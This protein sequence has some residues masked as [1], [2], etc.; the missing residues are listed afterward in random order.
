M[1][2]D[3]PKSI[4]LKN[5]F[6]LYKSLKP[7]YMKDTAVQLYNYIS[8]IDQ[9]LHKN[10]EIEIKLGKIKLEGNYKLYEYVKEVFL[11]PN[12]PN[13][14]QDK[15]TFESN[16]PQYFNLIWYYLNKEIE[17]GAKDIILLEPKLYKELIFQDKRLSFC[18]ID[19]KIVSEEVIYKK[20]KH[21][22]NI[23]Y[24][25][26][27]DYRITACLEMPVEVNTDDIL[28]SYREKLRISYKFQ[29]FRV[30]F[31]V[32]KS[33]YNFSKRNINLTQPYSESIKDLSADEL[34][35]PSITYELEVEFDELSSFLKQTN[36]EYQQFENMIGRLIENINIFIN[37]AN[38]NTYLNLTANES[39]D[40]Q[41]GNYFKYNLK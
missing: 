1:K 6:K 3:I 2:D 28:K 32:V 38:F 40:S 18:F 35:Y 20:N 30:D 9:N 19:N 23:K 21:H 17:S 24:N 22:F 10:I 12:L 16:V 37:C 36:Y 7:S 39:K 29:Y 27:L 41:F 34:G 26:I 15:I 31:T 8:S 11:L 14:K 13:N 4:I 25:D 5:H 33:I